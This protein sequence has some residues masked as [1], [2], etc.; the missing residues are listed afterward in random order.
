MT[1]PSAAPLTHTGMIEAQRAAFLEGVRY[2]VNTAHH[3][4]LSL[5]DGCKLCKG[6]A[7]RLYP[8]PRKTVPRVVTDSNGF[9]FRVSVVDGESIVQVKNVSANSEHWGQ[10][11]MGITEERAQLFKSLFS[12]PTVE[13]DADD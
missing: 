7:A 11:V 13:V 9:E 1:S 5:C 4:S 3:A 2:N 8:L 12:N 10:S 6:E